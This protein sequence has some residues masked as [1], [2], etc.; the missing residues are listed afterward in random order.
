MTGM[1]QNDNPYPIDKICPLRQFGYVDGVY[2]RM[3]EWMCPYTYDNPCLGRHDGLQLLDIDIGRFL[4]LVDVV[5][6]LQRGRLVVASL[7]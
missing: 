1:G 3:T 4:S 5:G 6:L 2:V 7:W